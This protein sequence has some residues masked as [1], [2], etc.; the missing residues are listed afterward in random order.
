[1]IVRL[2]YVAISN[3]VEDT[4]SSPYTYKEYLNNHNMDKLDSVILSNLKALDNIIDYNI[5]NNI[6]FYRISSKIIPLATK[7]DVVFNYTSKYKEYYDKIAL[8][9]KESKIRVDFHPDEFCVLN[10]TNKE[11]FN[12][13][14]ESLK[15][16]Y[17]ILKMLK[18]DKK[19]LILHIGS[20][21]FG[22]ENSIRRF[23][24]NY[25]KLPNYI[26]ECIV[27]ENDDKIF[28]IEDT[29]KISEETGIPIVLDY[30]HHNCNK[31]NID[32]TKIFKSWKK[33]NP[34]IHFSSPK[35]K[36]EFRSHSD[37]IDL[38]SFI[39][40]IEEIKIYDTDID[41]MLE[42]KAKDD[43]LF[44]LIRQLKYKTEYKFIDDTTFIIKKQDNLL[45]K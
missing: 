33:E 1:M 6:H 24:N 43:A 34:K 42:A 29:T 9:I 36:K 28:N 15:Y 20:S 19:T 22:K 27:I 16:H 45:K 18:V 40:F 25:N 38:D 3:A 8:K 17:K 41:I 10:S 12:N 32:Y 11:V 35:N 39:K 26:K 21:A 44:R 2:G 14:M 13:T 31:G 37:Y 23:I 4:T 30:H 7:S 5:K